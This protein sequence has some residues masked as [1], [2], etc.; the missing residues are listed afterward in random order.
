MLL[1]RSANLYLQGVLAGY[2]RK[3]KHIKVLARPHIPHPNLLVAPNLSPYTASLWS[4]GLSLNVS[5]FVSFAYVS[6]SLGDSQFSWAN[7]S[8][9]TVSFKKPFL[10]SEET[11]FPLGFPSLPAEWSVLEVLA[12]A[13]SCPGVIC[14]LRN[15]TFLS[16]LSPLSQEPCLLNV[17]IFHLLYELALL[18][19]ALKNDWFHLV[20]KKTA[21]LPWGEFYMYYVLYKNPY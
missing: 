6:P 13:S 16:T 20:G 4:W 19:W 21:W 5:P 18:W 12:A 3:P 1:S 7:P 9:N 8:S 14:L 2:K 11:P 17:C 10:V 15:L